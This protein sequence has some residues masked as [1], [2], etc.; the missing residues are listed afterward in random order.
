M[1]DAYSTARIYLI[2]NTVN[3]KQY[4]GQTH[5]TLHQRWRAHVVA[6]KHSPYCRLLYAAM[7]KYGVESFRIDQIDEVTGSQADVDAAESRA[8]N[9]HGTLSPGGYNLRAGGGRGRVHAETKALMSAAHKGKPKSPEH[10]AAIGAAHKGRRYPPEFSRKIW[11]TRRANGTDKHTPETRAKISASNKGRRQSKNTRD[12]IRRAH[13]GSKRS[14]ETCAKIRARALERAEIR[15]ADAL[16]RPPKPK[17]TKAKLATCTDCGCQIFRRTGR[18][19][20]CRACYF[21]RRAKPL[22]CVVCGAAYRRK[23]G[24]WAGRN[25]CSRQCVSVAIG[26]KNTR[27]AADKRLQRRLLFNDMEIMA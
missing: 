6:V 22:T 13:L 27:I 25:V 7:R 10:R 23:S 1:T 12:A 3:G 16:L 19:G 21:V 2:T 5:L 17:R 15:R 18:T 4:V 14:P 8:I 9:Q 11:E 20:R 24:V 26:L